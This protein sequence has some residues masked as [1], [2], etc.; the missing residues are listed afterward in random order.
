[1]TEVIKQNFLLQLILHEKFFDK[2][3]NLKCYYITTN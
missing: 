2:Q 3:L 1:M